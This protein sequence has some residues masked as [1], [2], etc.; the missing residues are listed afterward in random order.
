MAALV[1]SVIAV[2]ILFAIKSLPGP[3]PARTQ[4][5]KSALI[6]YLSEYATFSTGGQNPL[7]PL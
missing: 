3:S 5:K 1:I 7:E 6:Q 4:E 2:I